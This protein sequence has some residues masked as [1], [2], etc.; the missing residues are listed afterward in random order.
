MKENDMA[1]TIYKIRAPR[2]L[3]N[4]TA[5]GVHF[6][7]IRFLFIRSVFYPLPACLKGRG[8]GVFMP[9]G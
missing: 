1:S 9:L 7:P 4:R 2:E 5:L 8:V 6:T 3:E